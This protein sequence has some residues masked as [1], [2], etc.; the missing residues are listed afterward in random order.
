MPKRLALIL[1]DQLSLTLASLRDADPETDHILM[2][3]VWDEAQ[4]VRHHKKKIALIFAAMRHFGETLRG[5]G[6]AVTYVRLDD[7]DNT[8]SLTGELHRHAQALGPDEIW[9]TE[10]GE[11]RLRKA[12][13]GYMAQAPAPV[14][15]FED[16]R[17]LCSTAD[18]ADWAKGRKQL[19]MEYFYR[20]MRR[21]TGLLMDG[22]TPEGGQWNYDA[23]NRKPAEADLFMPH[24][25]RFEP[26]D[27][28]REVLALV[29]ARFG[30]HFGDLEP[31]W[32]AVTA[33]DANAAAD[34]FITAQL[35]DFGTYQ[36]AMLVGERFLYHSVLSV[37][38]NIGLLDPLDLCTRVE[39]AYKAGKVPLNS[40]EGF[41]RQ[42]IGW[43]EYVR[44]IYFTAMPDYAARNALGAS[45]ALPDFYWTGEVDMT[46]L[47]E[48]ITQTREEAYAHHI[49]RLMITGNFALIAGVDPHAVHEWYLAVYADAFEWVEMP[50]TIGMSQ[51]ADGGLLGSKPYA[52]SGNYIN[53]MSDYCAHC[54]YD[55]K[56]KTGPD[57]CPFNALYWD[58]MARNRKTLDGNPRLGRVFST[59]DRMTD[60]TRAAYRDSAQAF[61]S[62][63]FDG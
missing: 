52:A 5:A 51:F 2:A 23:D 63:L 13:E 16:D 14:R 33:D 60:D 48:A 46:C 41:I 22:D 39:A 57:A 43:R 4:Y 59:W 7:A 24:P 29:G 27:I 15:I 21:K 18:F 56:Q 38:I 55:V 34:H 58:F 26:D 12:F 8:G 11:W 53:K 37:Y 25:K 10:A 40:A 32:F 28:T 45:R 30:D 54:R 61:L 50:N 3:E 62:T 31:F 44:G 42:I 35:A 20:D 6:Y 49:Q 36:D 1:G 19:R 17:F 47:R 9:I